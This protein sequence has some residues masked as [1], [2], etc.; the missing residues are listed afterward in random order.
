MNWTEEH[1]CGR[2]SSAHSRAM[3]YR[4]IPSEL[5]RQGYV[6][7]LVKREGDVSIYSKSAGFEVLRVRRH[8]GRMIGET[9]VEPAEYLPSDE[10]F[11]TKGWYFIGPNAR[12]LAETKMRAL[13]AP[14][15]SAA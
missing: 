12:E 3:N 7:R 2:G 6:M 11:G 1:A 4:P 15:A 8:D 14:D 13:A 5:K 10:E 9:V